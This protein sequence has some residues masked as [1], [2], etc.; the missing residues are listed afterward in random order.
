MWTNASLKEHLDTSSVVRSA[1]AVHVEWNL[2]DPE[3]IDKIG[4]YR[5]RPTSNGISKTP[6]ITYD[7]NDS[8]GEY[9]GA[10][11]ADTIIEGELDDNNDPEL[12]ITPDEKFQ[13]L[14]SLDDCF[15]PNR[16]R[17]G[18][19][20]LLMIEGRRWIPANN[21]AD[22]QPRYYAA[23][24]QDPFK[25]WTSYRLI[26][27]K[28]EPNAQ[29]RYPGGFPDTMPVGISKNNGND[30]FYIED[31]CP[32][33]VYKNVVYAN[34]IT[35]KMQTH[36]SD[37]EGNHV[38]VNGTDIGDP[39]F[40][41]WNQQTPTHWTVQVL[42]N[43]IWSDA[44]TATAATTKED[45]SSI[46]G[47][48]GHV[49]LAYGLRIPSGYNYID[50]VSSQSQL[51]ENPYTYDAYL[52]ASDQSPGFLY[53]YNGSWNIE[54]AIYD[55]HL[56]ESDYYAPLPID[57]I[58][59]M[60][61]Y[62][63]GM[64]TRY[65][66]LD[67][68]QGIRL[69][70][71]E[72]NLVDSTFD[73]I[74]LSPRMV[75]DVT[76]MVESYSIKSPAASMDA[77]DLPVGY[78][79][80]G[81]GSITLV[82]NES[83]FN[84]P[85]SIFSALA[86]MNMKFVFYEGADDVDGIIYHIPLKT[87]YNE[88][89]PPNMDEP[90][91]I[92]F[93]LRDAFWMLEKM[94]APSL[95]MEN[96]SLS[97]AIATLLDYIG[98]SNYDFK[99][100][101]KEEVIIPYF[102]TSNEKT[103]AEVLQDLARSTQ[104]AMF[105]DEYNNFIVMY[106]D[107]LMSTQRSVDAVLS[108]NSTTPHIIS[109][110]SA[111]KK[112]YN[113]GKIDY[114][115]RYIQ[116]SIASLQQASFINEDQL[117]IYKPVLLWEAS[118]SELV[119]A[120]NE[121]GQ[122]QSAFSL[123][124]CVLNTSLSNTLPYVQNGQVKNN[125]IDLGESVY[126]LPRY[127]G[128][129]Y[130]N[131]EIIKFDAVEYAITGQ[132]NVWI[133]NNAEYQKYFADVPFYGKIYPTG[134]IRIY[135]EAEYARNQDGTLR[136]IGIKRH[137]R[138][139]FQTPIASHPA[140]L[141]DSWTSTSTRKVIEQDSD[142][143]FQEKDL[144]DT[145][146]YASSGNGKTQLNGGTRVNGIIKNHFRNV[147]YTET[148]VG[149]FK[150]AR[151]GT[152]QSSAMVLQ[153]VKDTT[154]DINNLF[155]VHKTLEAPFQHYGTRMRI[156]GEVKPIGEVT[157]TAT[158]ES[159][160][161]SD[162]AGIGNVLTGGSG[163]IVSNFNSSNNTGYFFEIIALSNTTIAD[164]TSNDDAHNV[165]FYKNMASS[166]SSSTSKSIPVKMWGGRSNIVVDSGEF[167]GQS[168]QATEDFPSVYDL[169]I[170]S[171]QIG[172]GRR[173]F[174]YINGK[175]VGVVD[176]PSPLPLSNTFGVFSRG[177]SKLMFENVYALRDTTSTSTLI[178]ESLPSAFG[179]TEVNTFE[180]MNKYAINGMI[181]NSYLDR[182]NTDTQPSTQMY[183]DE[184]GTIMRECAYFNIKFDKAYPAL[185]AKISPTFNKMQ[186]YFVSGFSHHAY[187]AE[188]LVFNATDKALNLDETTGN[189]LRIQ[190]V[191]FTQTNQRSLTIDELYNEISSASDS[192]TSEMGVATDPLLEKERFRDIRI[193]R[194]RRGRNE[195]T[196]TTEYVQRQ[197]DAKAL[198]KWLAEELTRPRLLVGLELFP[199]P[200]LQLGDIVTLDYTDTNNV[201]FASD[202]R[203]VVYNI[204]YERNG[205]GLSHKAYLCEV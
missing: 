128:Y 92:K 29:N 53:T 173:F 199:Y 88:A 188:F 102:Y 192:Y 38:I 19:N 140:G 166:A 44:Y 170:E 7:P 182:I 125:I 54:P 183:F 17:S 57:D 185:K 186:T 59:N 58:A 190:G 37:V 9:T 4:N 41:W 86:D 46:I 191:A 187:G 155:V 63:N 24:K 51:P 100:M 82:D 164:G 131:G 109:V 161:Y 174:L 196:L 10:T 127:D 169:A 27:P 157:Q 42:K 111:E 147:Q 134:R 35:I 132:G 124:A 43:G 48:D 179:D 22:G 65:R 26:S 139:Q 203:F 144:P 73:L 72:M 11:L 123:G 49:E 104:S 120:N 93:E 205:E 66:D 133:S 36:A 116:R 2:N 146:Y 34:R 23:S 180:A 99:R 108:G 12:Y 6:V 168:R 15:Q 31:A 115:E 107:Y 181:R 152:V 71:K 50:K 96:V 105:F 64:A 62:Y 177:T 3:N 143:L 8:L 47:P 204:E 118:G 153:G 178:A 18:I 67:D 21:Y 98:F 138:S 90:P 165:I 151:A 101:D 79:L 145:V 95:F 112:R 158:G 154:S 129:F 74:E 14:F 78:L 175:Q 176:D 85:N 156:V 103:V 137:G 195:F 91:T 68:I 94:K 69:I 81:T 97:V 141:S 45:G 77:T 25:Y 55:W 70:V 80:P 76:D 136:I 200:I 30:I 60:E 32:F 5:H 20:K 167:V 130:A 121:M 13:T 126:W 163:G 184:F 114:N 122:N 197:D 89:V 28:D 87:M 1:S 16:P 40:G 194:R 172:T 135:T 119:R 61:T 160:Y 202:R 33:V 148:E 83:L 189:Y 171:K 162:A 150:T 113:D 106:K 39:T 149:G 110:A 75:V 159:T 193:D 84:D 142:Y 198:M 56:V 52:V 117:L 201:D